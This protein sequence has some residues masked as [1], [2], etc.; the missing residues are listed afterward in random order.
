MPPWANGRQ[1]HTQGVRFLVTHFDNRR[2]LLANAD[3]SGAAD[4]IAALQ[5]KVAAMAE[6]IAALQA[7]AALLRP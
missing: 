6:A 2:Q 4:A 7:G 1:P 3:M 5:A